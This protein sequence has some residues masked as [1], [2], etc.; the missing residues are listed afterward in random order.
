MKRFI[1]EVPEDQRLTLCADCPWNKNE[2]ICQYCYDNNICT[3]YD[4]S[5]A[6]LSEE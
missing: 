3:K 2:N 4:F 6:N 5:K 1:L